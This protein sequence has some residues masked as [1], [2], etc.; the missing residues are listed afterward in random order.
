MGNNVTP[1]HLRGFL[2]PSITLNHDSI[3][4]AQSTYNQKNARA[5]IP[6][7]QQIQTSMALQAIGSQDEKITIETIQGGTP[8]ET[9]RYYW[10]DTNGNIYGRDWKSFV[11]QWDYWDY[12]S[13]GAVGSYSHLDSIET[14]PGE[15]FVVAE[16]IDTSG[17]Y[18]VSLRKKKREQ[19]VTL[20]HTF[21]SEILVTTPTSQG[22]PAIL[23]L[24]D[25][26]LYVARINYTSGDSTNITAY[27][28]YDNGDN[29]QTITT[30]ALYENIDIGT[31]GYDIKD[32]RLTTQ[33]NVILLFLELVSN[34]GTHKN[35]VA[36]YRSLDDG[37]TFHLVG[38]V[39]DGTEGSFHSNR[40]VTLPNNNVGCAYISDIHTIKFRKIPNP[41]IRFSS[42]AWATQEITIQTGS[43]QWATI[44]GGELTD[45]NL[46]IWYQDSRI[47]VIAERYNDGRFYG[48]FS[49][50]NGDSWY[51]IGDGWVFRFGDWNN[52]LKHIYVQPFESR[53]VILGNHDDSAHMLYLG[54]Y[55]TAGAPPLFTNPPEDKY[56]TWQTNW[57]PFA[58]PDTSSLWTTTGTGSQTVGSTGL[59]IQTSINTR[60]Y[61]YT[62]TSGLYFSQGQLFRFRLEVPSSVPKT[63]NFIAFQATQ[64]SG[65]A[66]RM[67]NI[68]FS[69]NGFD[70]RD[71]TS[72]LQSVSH[73]LTNPTEFLIGWLGSTAKI[74]Y[75]TK[76][77]KPKDWN[78]VT[79]TIPS[80]A[81]GAGNTVL[82]GHMAPSTSQSKWQEFFVSSGSSAGLGDSMDAIPAPYPVA[83]EYVYISQGLRITTSSSPA[84]GEDEYII[85]PR[86]DF[87][88][89]NIFHNIS[90]SPRIP[91][92]SEGTT[93]QSIALYIDPNIQ[94]NERNHHIN[95]VYGL[96]LANVNF[97]E[98]LLKR[99][100]GA[101]WD[102][103]YAFDLSD[104]LTGSFERSG[105]SIQSSTT[106]EPFYLHFNEAV[107]WRAILK[108]GENEYVVKIIRN[109]EG[110][111]G[112]NTDKK[113]CVLVFDAEETDYATL[114]SSGTIELIPDRATLIID[115]LGDS[116]LGDSALR[117][118]LPTQPLLEDYFQIG[119][120][121]IGPVVFVA[122]QYQRGR[123][124]SF[125]PN[126]IEYETND[127][128]FYARKMSNGRRTASIAWTEP[129]DT[130][131]VMEKNPD[132]WQ[133]SQTTGA[134]PVAN[135]GDAPFT[136]MGLYQAVYNAQPLVY[137]PA[138]KKSQDTQIL[139]RYHDHILARTTGQI[140]IESVIGEEAKTEMFRIAT[141]NIIEVE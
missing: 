54:G 131:R 93:A 1:D 133:L 138:V 87:P 11:S 39:S 10:E 112:K 5:G 19:S 139:N 77:D 42:S 23:Q 70:I 28:S 50:D 97:K 14:V 125:E 21:F 132:Y 107:G 30:R 63:S 43:I 110:A 106:G 58:T 20:V 95:D 52:R 85:E 122:P 61:T 9:A 130:T 101:S 16:T 91:W 15:M 69:N 72:I 32:M 25:D 75:R 24:S 40:P 124:I 137:L 66:S 2:I 59:D 76:N 67:L 79:V 37:L 94:A 33:G 78:V 100:N 65:S 135:Y 129:I 74:H 123:T 88:V 56:A 99:W 3:W 7:A 121:I 90:L 115:A 64:D 38:G 35:R 136:M 84:R 119:T 31:S 134:Q 126:I 55:T 71:N 36:Q 118:E 62:G 26:A 81:T 114:P 89:K 108:S 27:R 6:E 53:A 140:S 4:E 117:L 104:G 17:R 105:S 116:T 111:W 60:F 47:F 120:M 96:H 113:R 80:Y 22:H 34:T 45:G 98:G 83:G 29:W 128:M 13:S 46:A 57:V 41:N 82:W 109:S 51:A 44:S 141:I 92:R 86:Y 18:T 48:W 102:T 73:P 103:V 12:R 68:R 8:G 49:S 127:N